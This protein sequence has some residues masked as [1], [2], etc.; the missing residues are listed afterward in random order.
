MQEA[1]KVFS[2]A[3]SL[4][5]T[6]Q[7]LTFLRRFPEAFRVYTS[8]IHEHVVSPM[9]SRLTSRSVMGFFCNAGFD[10]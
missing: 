4:T 8:T 2:E 3:S 5:N 7:P 6:G 10:E 1:A 9:I